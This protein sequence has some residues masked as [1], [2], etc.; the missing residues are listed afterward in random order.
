MSSGFCG[1]TRS[2]GSGRVFIDDTV[3][4][5]ASF[6][7]ASPAWRRWRVRIERFGRISSRVL[8]RRSFGAFGVSRASS[9]RSFSARRA[10]RPSSAGRGR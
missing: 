6:Q 8:A 9:R 7:D 4:S 1:S 5:D 2:A 3:E 10:R